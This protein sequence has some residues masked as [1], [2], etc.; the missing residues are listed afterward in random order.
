MAYTGMQYKDP[1]GGT[2]SDIGAQFRTDKY[3]RKAL[4]DIK[5]EQYFQQLANVEAMPRNF[6]KKLKK[7]QYI[8]LLDDRNINSQ[9]LDANGAVIAGGNLYGS[10][11]DVGAISGKLPVL[12]EAGGFVNRVGWTRVDLEG[13]LHKYGFYSTYTQ[14]SMDFDTDAELEMHINREMLN[15]A[16][17]ITEDKLQ[18]DLLNFGTTHR[19]AGNASTIATVSGEAGSVCEIDYND[20]MRLSIDL[21][22]NRTPKQTTIITGSRMIDTK[23]VRAARLLYMGSEMI[24]TFESMQDNFGKQAFV[25]LAH[26]AEAG[27]DI[28]GEYGAVGNFRVIVVPEMMHFAGAGATDTGGDTL[29]KSTSGKYDVFPL[30]CIGEES[31]STIGFKTDGK[32]FKF[33]IK[34]SKPGSPESYANDPFGETG[35]MSIK[36]YY[37]FL[38]LR[39]ERIGI[40]YSV[41]RT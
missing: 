17:E 18:I 15:G 10:S 36:W 32:S 2:P 4:I 8:P 5:K 13:S 40:A 11:K 25:P 24:P 35:F 21:D 29:Y 39:S 27:S 26:Y 31:F 14:E 34:H 16:N 20:L 22:D 9:G 28:N 38:G 12:S 7:Y 6:G 37:G 23:V 33:K 30:M 19:F 3:L 1:A 41:A